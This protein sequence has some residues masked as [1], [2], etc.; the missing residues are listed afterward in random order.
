MKH[1]KL[2]TVIL[3]AGLVLS[4]VA[5]AGS[6][7]RSGG[8]SSHS[9]SS[10]SG[11]SSSASHSAPAPRAPSAAPAPSHQGGIGGTQSSVGV[12]KSEV[13][14][15]VKQDVAAS[16]PA[17]A[18]GGTTT[19]STSPQYSSGP[20]YSA[21][22]PVAV[23]SNSGFGGGF[24]SSFAGALGGTL[25]G[26][27]L[28]GNHGHGGGTTVINNGTPSNS[29]QSNSPSAGPSA[30]IGDAQFNPGG[31]PSQPKKEYTVWSFIADLIGFVFVVAILLGIA[32]L[33]YK[34]YQMVRNYVNQ[35]RGVSNTPFN[36]TQRFWE[37]QKAFGAADSVA[38]QT[39]LGPD[40]VDELTMDLQPSTVT[41]KNVSHEVRLNTTTEFS[42]WYKF[43]EIDGSEINQ[44]WHYE[45]FDKEWKLNGIENV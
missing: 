1:A 34:G 10:S 44:V 21:P 20:A 39:L 23:Q 3:T 36:P 8:S 18:G 17:P 26:N 15:G 9:S 25:V 4:Q 37:I 16:K 29:V 7:G 42:I 28:F 19:P 14:N 5:V 12:R 41:V 43:F 11:R 2:V 24:G 38:L 30:N 33:F 45:K 31:L 13:T 40:V 22:P 32:W 27:A 6:I 35:E